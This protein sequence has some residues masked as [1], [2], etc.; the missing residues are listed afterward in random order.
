MRPTDPTQLGEFTILEKIGQGAMGAVYKAHQSSLGRVVA[1]KLLPAHYAGDADFVARFKREASAAAALNHPNIV[2]I[3][4]AGQDE[5]AH[6][7]AMEFVEGES[8]G[9]RLERKGRVDARQVLAVAHYIAQALDYAWKKAGV[10]HR[11]IKPDNIFLSREGDV[12]LGDLGLA[13][14]LSTDGAGLTQTGTTMGTPYYVSPEQAV[15]NKEIDFRADIYSLGCTIFHAVSGQTPYRGDSAMSVMI[16]HITQAAPKIQTVWPECP[17]ALVGLL[18]RMLRKKPEERHESYEVLLQQLLWVGERLDPPSA[19]AAAAMSMVVPMPGAPEASAAPAPRS[20]K[21]ANRSAAK[22]APVAGK[23]WKIPALVAGFVGVAAGLALWQPWKKAAPLSVKDVATLS[24]PSTPALAKITTPA[25]KV[26][27]SPVIQPSGATFAQATKEAPFVNSLGMKFVPVPIIGGP[28]VGQRVLFSVWE[29]RVQDYETFARETNYQWGKPGFEQGPMHPAVEVTWDG[30]QAFCGWLTERERKVGRLGVDEAYRLPSDYEWSCAVGIGDREDPEKTPEEKNGKIRDVYPWGTQWPPPPGAGNYPGDEMKPALAAGKYSY[31][32]K[33]IPGYKDGYVETAPVGSF[34]SNRY[35]LYDMGGN[36]WEW[37][38]DW[39]NQKHDEKTM[40][41]SPWDAPTGLTSSNR[42][43]RSAATASPR[44]GLRCVLA[45]V[46]RGAKT[47]VPPIATAKPVS[48]PA[49]TTAPATPA[50]S[51]GPDAEG[52]VALFDSEHLAA[53]KELGNGGFSVQDGVAT[54]W[55]TKKPGGSWWY[56]REPYNDFVLK[57]EFRIATPMA[58]SG[59]FVRCPRP[60]GDGFASMTAGYQIDVS[61]D[62]NP[63]EMTGA[64]CGLK[65]PTSV[66]QNK[67]DWNELEISVV[68]QHYL[69]KVNGILVNDF[70]GNRRTSGYIG[71]QEYKVGGLQFRNFRIKELNASTPLAAA[72]PAEVRGKNV[73]NLLSS[74]DLPADTVSGTFVAKADGSFTPGNGLAKLE[75]P[76]RPPAEYDYSVTFTYLEGVGE[77]SQMLSRGGRAFEWQ[78]G[79]NGVFFGFQTIAGKNAAQNPTTK[80]FHLEKNRKYTSLVQVRNDGLKAYIDGALIA[81]W[82]T[83]YSDMG[84]WMNWK[85]R[86]DARL[87][88]GTLSTAATIHALEV[89]EIT[90]QGQLLRPARAGP[91]VQVAPPQPALKGPVDGEGFTSLFNGR[92]LT[93]WDADPRFWSVREGAITGECESNRIVPANTFAIWTGG[94]PSDFE[95]RLSFK[96]NAG[97]SGVQYRSRVVDAARWKVLGYQYEIETVKTGTNGALYE[98]GGQRKALGGNPGGLFLANLGEKVL[99][100]ADDR[101]QLLGNFSTPFKFRAN[102]WNDL[103]I[104][105]QGNHLIQKLN[106][107]ISID[108]TDDDEKARAL[109]GV[110]ALQ[111]HAGSPQKVQFKNIRLKLLSA[112]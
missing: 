83:N 84:P 36:A 102:D 10:V 73:I 62:P 3:Y 39:Y 7:F 31:I 112:P 86:D 23:A 103:V 100:T 107:D 90:G 53:W 1:L 49:P 85:L 30:A 96:V 45:A 92:D 89:L 55:L 94:K 18:D 44:S 27:T 15:G 69:V 37:C 59:V 99:M 82:K 77:I 34:Q 105:A 51:R 22:V 25:P 38:E 19:S 63:V 60:E 6:Y 48:T 101:K 28:T 4:A 21:A 81:E 33:P 12:K 42:V 87:G 76:Y 52:F 75:L 74:V 67:R 79:G 46:N 104:I 56:M 41:D 9:A 95:L 16:Q 65:A 106:G 88:V 110:L 71:L 97:N 70:T 17:P 8:L 91:S 20:S 14:V 5:G 57:T 61:E 108:L 72:T 11:D 78:M 43:N 35:G 64:I 47:T 26:D 80:R 29:T 54:S 93:G 2:Q 109:S 50:P 24:A 13:K 98:E 68:S 66:P 58:N 111:L 40:R 32:G